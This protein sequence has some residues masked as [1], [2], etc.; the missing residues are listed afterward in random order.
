MPVVSVSLPL[1]DVVGSGH[2]LMEAMKGTAVSAIVVIVQLLNS[3]Q[4][5]APLI[6]FSYLNFEV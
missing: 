2:A 5:Q 1:H 6:L 4:I 3:K